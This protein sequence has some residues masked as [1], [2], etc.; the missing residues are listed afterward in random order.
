[1]EFA[2]TSEQEMIRS[3][4][5]EFLRRECPM[6]V[7]RRLMAGEHAES[8]ELWRKMADLGWMGL[9]FPEEYGGATLSFVE[10]AVVLEE[11]GCAL[12]PGAYFSTVLLGGLTLLEAANEEQ[13]RRWLVPLAGGK[14]KATLAL[15]ETDERS[16]PEGIALKAERS[17]NGYALNGTKL[18]VPDAGTADLI[19]CAARTGSSSKTSEGITLCAIDRASD[20]VKVTP[21][22][23]MDETRRIDEVT[24]EQARVS[25]D[26]VLGNVGAAWPVIEQVL[27]LATISLCAEMAG[28]ARRVLEL[29]VEYLKTRVQ[30]GRPIG[31]F[32]ALQHRCADMLLLIES[33]K[34]AVYAAACAASDRSS[35][36]PLLA[37]IAKAWTSDAYTQVAGEGIQLHGGMGF[38]W[39]HD[40]HLYFKRA[41]ADELTFG[42]A[43]HHR[44]RVAGMIGL[45]QNSRVHDQEKVR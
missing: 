11:M 10:L 18:F 13:K 42:D 35:D 4:A 38:T 8:D 41:K 17:G 25:S 1:M 15:L 14:L 37:S 29:C 33:A 27:D 30:F 43:T 21:L 36:L 28:G 39:E 16:G 22:K 5:A 3:Q 32:Q 7:V 12:V 26:R 9:I 2:F 34:S 44:A 23:T 20:G 24:F 40:A 6:N 45:T 31:S 19:L